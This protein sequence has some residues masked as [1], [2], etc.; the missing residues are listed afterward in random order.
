VINVNLHLH[1][2]ILD[3]EIGHFQDRPDHIHR[4]DKE[5]MEGHWQQSGLC[6]CAALSE[7]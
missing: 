6:C 1:G 3:Y 4:W 7:I 2:A 5:A